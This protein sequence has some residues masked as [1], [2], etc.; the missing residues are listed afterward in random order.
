LLL[1]YLGAQLYFVT[2]KNRSNDGFV[3]AACMGIT[4]CARRCGILRSFA[5][6]HCVQPFSSYK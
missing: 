1:D 4:Y 6:L 5:F 2:P 3:R